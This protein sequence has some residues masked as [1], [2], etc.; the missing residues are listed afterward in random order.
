[1]AS[2]S[3]NIDETVTENSVKTIIGIVT[4][5]IVYRKTG[6]LPISFLSGILSGFLLGKPAYRIFNT[7]FS[8]LDTNNTNNNITNVLEKNTLSSKMQKR[9]QEICSDNNTINVESNI[10]LGNIIQ[11]KTFSTIVFDKNNIISKII[12]SEIPKNIF[13]IIHGSPGQGK[14]TL[15]YMFADVLANTYKV[16]YFLTEEGFSKSVQKKLH[17][18]K[19]KNA[20][21]IY[22]SDA[23][24]FANI[25]KDI[26]KT[27]PDFVFIDSINH[28]NIS[29]EELEYLR[30]T[31]NSTGFFC[32]FQERKDGGIRADNRFVHNSDVVIKVNNM[33]AIANEKNRYA[34]KKPYLVNLLNCID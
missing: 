21:K 22:F 2:K 4:G 1:M 30:K 28:A 18:I 6:N 19:S 33:K 8:P 13:C 20:D 16:L 29:V 9:K 10:L 14:S 26:E 31:Y 3:E 34:D 27:Q 5:Q 7:I 12:G 25:Q 15:S 11:K 24:S 17:L 32:V 23:Y